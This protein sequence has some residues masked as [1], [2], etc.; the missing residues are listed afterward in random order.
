M[1]VLIALI[2]VGGRINHR[3]SKEEELIIL[4]IFMFIFAAAYWCYWSWKKG[5]TNK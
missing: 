4:G 3:F 2:Y 5:Q 1:R